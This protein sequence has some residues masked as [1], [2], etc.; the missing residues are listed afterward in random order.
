MSTEI[1]GAKWTVLEG[2]VHRKCGWE[3]WL[4]PSGSRKLF[5]CS[6]CGVI[7]NK[8]E[9]GKPL[10]KKVKRIKEKTK[11]QSSKQKKSRKKLKKKK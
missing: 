1:K 3:V 10:Q 7:K 4:V 11:C 6:A 2:K 8:K 9:I 5:F